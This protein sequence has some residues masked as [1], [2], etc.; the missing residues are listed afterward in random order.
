MCFD[1]KLLFARYTIWAGKVASQVKGAYCQ[2]PRTLVWFP[3]PTKQEER[4][5]F[6]KLSCDFHMLAEVFMCICAHA[7]T[8]INVITF[9]SFFF[10]CS[11]TT[12]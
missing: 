3:G 11:D 4:K 5:D 6:C 10:V 1:A 8:E 12:V 2:S 9:K 7:H